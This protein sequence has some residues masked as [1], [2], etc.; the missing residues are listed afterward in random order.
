[1]HGPEPDDEVVAVI[2]VT[3]DGIESRQVRRMPFD[4]PAAA[5]EGSADGLGIDD[6]D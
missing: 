1:M 6:L 5:L 2:A 4:D 3:E